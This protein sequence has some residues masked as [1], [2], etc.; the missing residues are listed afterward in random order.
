M[1]LETGRS[2]LPSVFEKILLS[3]SDSACQARDA[4]GPNATRAVESIRNLITKVVNAEFNP[5]PQSE[6]PP[7]TDK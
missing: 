7:R 3:L 4:G 6:N 5:R 2:P 1:S